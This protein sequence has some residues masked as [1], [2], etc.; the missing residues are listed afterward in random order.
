MSRGPFADR[1]VVVTGG[2][3]GIGRA[4]CARFLGSD[5]RVAALDLDREAL[6]KL[7]ADL[8][9]ERLMTAVV[10]IT[11]ADAVKQALTDVIAR[12]GG[13]D[14]LVNNAGLV[15]RSSFRETDAG[16]LRRVMEVNYFGSIN[17]TKA[18]L[19]SLVARR[20]MI[21]V[22]S[23]VAGLVPLFGRSGYSASKHALHGLFESIRAELADDGVGVLMVCPSFTTTPFEGRALG[24]SGDRV[25][26][27]RSKVGKEATPE[28]VADA[29]HDAV[30]ANKQLIVLSPV[31][32]LAVW[33]SRIAPA[34]Y[35][36]S[37]TKSL[38]SEL[39]G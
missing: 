14:V 32:K 15:H 29:I 18:A 8:A 27:P 33:L 39:D 22:I 19:E 11:D 6:A 37:M 34:L 2:A 16:V 35:Q 26:R 25:A 23:S 4:L 36:R 17:V 13:V 1:V 3:G 24:P 10:D 5:A 7:D 38:K 28:S 20:G 30:L 31:G 21:V 9:S 12:F